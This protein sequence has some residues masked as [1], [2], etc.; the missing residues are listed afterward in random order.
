MLFKPYFTSK[1]FTLTIMAKK[2]TDTHLFELPHVSKHLLTDAQLTYVRLEG[3][4]VICEIEHDEKVLENL[5][6]NVTID[7]T[8]KAK[9]IEKELEE[10][11]LL[12]IQDTS[13]KNSDK[14]R[15]LFEEGFSIAQITK[16]CKAHYSA[17]SGAVK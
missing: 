14:Y 16:L 6:K 10:E 15:Y 3:G 12:A 11:H 7:S 2:L 1:D 5:Y 4:I 13:L 17:V 8:V 9:G